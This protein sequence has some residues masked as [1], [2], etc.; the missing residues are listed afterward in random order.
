M[1][2]ATLVRPTHSRVRWTVC[3]LL[4]F[5]TTINYVDRQVLSL[6]AKTLETK[7]GWDSIQYSYITSAFTAAYAIGLLTAGRV[8]DRLGTRKGF[9]IAITVWSLAAMAHA[10]AVSAFTF[11]IARAFLGLGESANF[12]ACIKTVAEW[13]P[14][15]ERALS[16]GIFNSG[17][18]IG[19][20]V[21]PLTVPWLAVTF[22]WQSAFI[23]A[24]ALGFL[25]LAFW[26]IMYAKPEQ[27]PRIS[28][29][30]LALIRSDPADKAPS[31][32]WLRL[33]PKKET[34]AF[35]VGKFLTDPIWWFYLFWLPKYLQE[36]FSLTL[37]QITVPVL[38]VYNISS[39]GSIGGGWLSGGL[40]KRGWSLNGARKTAMLICAVAVLPVLYAPF[41]KNLWGVVALISLATAAHQGWSANLFTTVSDMFPRSAVG[42]V[43]G[44][45][46]TVGAIGG[47]LVQLAAGEIVQLTHSYLPLFIFAGCGYLVA[48]AIIH[49]LSP[50]LAPA[51]L[52]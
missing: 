34:W 8:I 17:A 31:Y 38:V 14:K 6:L 50:K 46:G 43:V 16:T 26:L 2:T 12:P 42:S 22:G 23:G 21:A 18:N 29:N 25:W 11:G 35:A 19:A 3:A 13:F 24:G 45:G 37:T 32:P 1:T 40:I 5:A 9:A 7:I 20:V 33:F 28:A 15:K 39:V 30:E 36:A 44:I 52:D 27:H 4:F 47:V 48:L 49:G 10:A 41:C 51:E